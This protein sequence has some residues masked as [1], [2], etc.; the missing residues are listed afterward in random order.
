MGAVF[1]ATPAGLAP[2]YAYS[3][4]SPEPSQPWLRNATF[5]AFSS[6]LDVVLTVAAS[7]SWQGN[8]AAAIAQARETHF[9]DIGTY[10][11]LSEVKNAV[12]VDTSHDTS[13]MVL[14]WCDGIG[15]RALEHALFAHAS[16]PFPSC[17]S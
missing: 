15:C 5:F 8:A 4:A 13:V 12:Q 3:P 1:K 6:Q 10:G 14:W 2:W 7:D 16:S 17:S 9:A 11:N